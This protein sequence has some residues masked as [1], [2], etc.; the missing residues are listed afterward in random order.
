M[1]SD[2]IQSELQAGCLVG[3]LTQ[4]A[5]TQVHV[6]PIDLPINEQWN[7]ISDRIRDVTVEVLGELMCVCCFPSHVFGHVSFCLS[8]EFPGVCVSR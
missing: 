5:V 3:P 1:V 8:E 6:S 7:V 4:A 2:Q